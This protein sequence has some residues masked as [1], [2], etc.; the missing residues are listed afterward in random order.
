MSTVDARLRQLFDEGAAHAEAIDGDYH[1]LWLA[2]GRA[3]EGGKRLRPALV[4]AT[5]GALGGRDLPLAARVGAAIELLHTAF[6]IHDDIIDGDE[7]RRGRPNV[8]GTFTERARSSGAPLD[9][10]ATFGLTAGILAGDLALVAAIRATALAGAPPRTT[11]RLLELVDRAVHVT[12]A[13]ELAD[14]RLSLDLAP[15]SLGEILTMEEHKTAVYSFELPLQA[16]AVLAGADAPLVRG[17]GD[18]GRLVGIGFQLLDDLQG[19]FGDEA[20]TGKSALSDL[21][22][23]KVTPLVAHA[24]STAAWPEIAPFVG[25]RGLTPSG[26]AVARDLL[27]RCGSR[28]FIEDLAGSYVTAALGV[29]ERLELPADLLDWV[30][31]MTDDLARRAA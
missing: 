30:T 6:V 14:V 26:A 21:R 11:E 3:G 31:S 1:Q 8:T 18:F 24:R 15:V 20:V 19:V 22:E 10:A 23:G 5:Y 4:T 2:L 9:R 29:A 7:T 25:D 17:L 27:T 12:A 13:G 16:G 28:R